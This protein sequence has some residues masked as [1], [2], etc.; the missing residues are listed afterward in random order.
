M[1]GALER[2]AVLA[3]LVEARRAARW[4]RRESLARL[5]AGRSDAGELAAV[6][7]EIDGRLAAGQRPRAWMA[8]DGRLTCRACAT[9]PARRWRVPLFRGSLAG[10]SCADA[11]CSACGGF[12]D[13][14]LK[15]RSE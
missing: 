15:G 7:D 8:R 2:G 13:S 5:A 11:V 10:Q 3:G 14:L 12:V 1:T 4:L 9:F 6:S